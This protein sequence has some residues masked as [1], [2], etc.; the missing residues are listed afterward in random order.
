MIYQVF[1]CSKQRNGMQGNLGSY[2]KGGVGER[3]GNTFL[4]SYS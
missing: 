4:C 3:S 2:L 1:V